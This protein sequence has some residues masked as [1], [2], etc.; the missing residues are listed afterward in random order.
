MK[1]VTTVVKSICPADELVEI[2]LPG[3]LEAQ[4][5]PSCETELFDLNGKAVS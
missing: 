4:G 2:D 3:F 5:D 1:E